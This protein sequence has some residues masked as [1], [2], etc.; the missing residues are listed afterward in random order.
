[1]KVAHHPAPTLRS[2]S[3]EVDSDLSA[4]VEKCLEKEPR[5]RYASAAALAEDLDRYLDGDAIAARS[6]GPIGRTIQ[7]TKQ[8]PIVAAV[9]G[10]HSTDAPLSQRR[11]QT[12]MIAMVFLMPIG[13]L[14]GAYLQHRSASAMPT[15]VRIAGGL[16][17]G[18]YTETARHL[19]EAISSIAG[20]SYE[21]S[22]TG[23]TWD[24]RDRLLSGEFDLAPMQASAVGGQ[25]LAVVAP[26]FY[27]AVHLLVRRD[28]PVQSVADLSGQEIAVGPQGSGSRRAAELVL[29]SFN[30]D[31]SACPRIVL[32]WPRLREASNNDKMSSK[33]PSVAIIC[34]G[35]GSDLVQS[36]LADKTWQL[37]S[38]TGSVNISLQ[39]PTLR[40]M[41]LLQSSY[42]GVVLPESGIETVGTTAFLV[43]QRNAPDRLIETALTA[44]YRE[45]VMTGLI[46]AK[47]AA[48]W[49]G[50]AFHRAART[51][52][53][54]IS[55]SD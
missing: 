24:N 7:W 33:I 26:L 25:E 14:S 39:H 52:F 5:R 23:G 8:I 22:P 51:Y 16:P 47:N 12:V 41:T 50:L 28:G 18:L 20:V 45:P 46:P 27:E 19:G 13:L 38:L 17:G 9:T 3:P 37:M 53:D 2:V 30:L 44:L 11:L 4:I 31:E 21:V 32:K 42:P 48:E 40:P 36:L 35:P 54:S 29:D 1:M 15:H 10:R 55:N 34:I 49:Q 43:S 6:M